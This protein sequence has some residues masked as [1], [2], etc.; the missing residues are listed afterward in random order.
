MRFELPESRVL[1]V[2]DDDRFRRGLAASLS[3]Y[4]FRVMEASTSPSALE[5]A[6]RQKPTACV[7]ETQLAGVDGIQF[8]KYL[9]SRHVFRLLPIIVVTRSITKDV[10]AQLVRLGV[11]SV[12]VKPSLAFEQ[13]VSKLLEISPTSD[14]FSPSATARV[15]SSHSPSDS[16]PSGFDEGSSFGQAASVV[17]MENREMPR[18]RPLSKDDLARHASLKAL[19]AV[20]EDVV[21]TASRPTSS[22]ED[23]EQV[24][25]KDPVIASQVIRAANS[26]AFMRGASVSRIDEALQLLGFKNVVRIAMACGIVSRS[27]LRRSSGDDLREIWRN[28]LCNAMV[29]E[30]LSPKQDG[31]RNYALALLRN[32]PLI[33]L[34][35]HLEGEWSAWRDWAIKQNLMFDQLVEAA[36]GIPLVQL[37]DSVFASMNL[38]RTIG[39]P[40]SEYFRFFMA[41][42]R[43]EPGLV[44]RKLDLVNQIAIFMG[45]PG[46]FLSEVRCIHPREIDPA[47]F[48]A[49]TCEE[50]LKELE[51]IEASIGIMGGAG[52]VGGPQ[53]GGVVVWRDSRWS[54]FDPIVSFLETISD[55]VTVNFVQDLIQSNR[56][57][58]AIAEPRTSEWEVLRTS[59]R[60]FVILHSE[61]LDTTDL[62]N[63]A[64]GIRL[65][66]PLCQLRSQL[67]KGLL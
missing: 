61:S 14:V 19:P 15:P 21:D 1:L 67:E 59:R 64:V 40:L 17:A 8:I 3:D 41:K 23:L 52:M 45:R 22:L 20:I 39:D 6:T 46:C 53:L 66:I 5:I 51:L 25:R 28:S 26:A 37:V 38:P 57:G 29:M 9:R 11:H 24:L 56:P 27:D 32:V 49:V 18:P 13:L 55:C 34:V 4:G 16:S 7:L 60:R 58:I 47:A 48:L 35:Q 31:A 42:E 65:P 50:F 63:G 54:P 2:D 10:L 43:M 36:C 44:A 62:P 33:L 12:F 30:R